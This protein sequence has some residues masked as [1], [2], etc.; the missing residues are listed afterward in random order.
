MPAM[1]FLKSKG[2]QL[3]CTGSIS[4]L[5]KMQLVWHLKEI[6]SGRKRERERREGGTEGGRKEENGVRKVGDRN[7]EER[8]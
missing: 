2:I 6:R 7:Q 5:S 1:I 3:P 4:L 8:V